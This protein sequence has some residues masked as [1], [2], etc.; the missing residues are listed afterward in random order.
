MEA[1]AALPL[2]EQCR[3]ERLGDE[4]VAKRLARRGDPV[5]EGH[6]G[7]GADQHRLAHK[8]GGHADCIVHRAGALD[9]GRQLAKQFRYSLRHGRQSLDPRT[10]V[11]SGAEQGPPFAVDHQHVSGVAEVVD[12]PAPIELA[13]E[14]HHRI[15]PAAIIAR[16]LRERA[17]PGFDGAPHH[18]LGLQGAALVGLRD[19]HPQQGGT[20]G[21]GDEQNAGKRAQDGTERHAIAIALTLR[22]SPRNTP[23]GPDQHP[24]DTQNARLADSTSPRLPS[25]CAPATSRLDVLLP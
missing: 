3:V 9:A 2:T 17:E 1:E 25:S 18:Q 19:Q 21:K 12:R 6:D 14:V 20:D 23:D 4:H 8:Q 7:H 11:R 10:A 16:H 5:A 15:V 24:L 22:R 13:V